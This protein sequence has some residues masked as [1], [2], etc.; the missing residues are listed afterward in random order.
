MITLLSLVIG[1]FSSFIKPA[2]AYFQDRQDKK[3]E[4]EMMQLQLQFNQANLN[5]K[6]EEV[7]LTQETQDLLTRYIPSEKNE[8]AAL[9]NE[10]TKTVISVTLIALYCI[11]CYDY[12]QVLSKMN[13]APFYATHMWTDEDYALLG[14]IIGYYFGTVVSG[15]KSR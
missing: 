4:L 13:D 14:A 7:R 11:V 8:V 5:A 6:L 12:N 15:K 9:V 2:F 3:Q 10:I 1:F